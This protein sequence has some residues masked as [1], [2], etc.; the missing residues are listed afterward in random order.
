MTEQASR[1]S[2]LLSQVIMWVIFNHLRLWITVA[3]HNLK[4]LKIK[5]K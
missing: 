3:R 1:F 2:K 4:G 5:I